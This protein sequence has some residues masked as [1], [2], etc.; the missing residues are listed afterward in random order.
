MT[1][2]RAPSPMSLPWYCAAALRNRTWL[3]L[4]DRPLTF[5]V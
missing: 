2:S 4:L 3:A 1:Q 5:N